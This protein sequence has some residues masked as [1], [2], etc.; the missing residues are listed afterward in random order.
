MATQ[1]NPRAILSTLDEAVLTTSLADY[2]PTFKDNVYNSNVVLRLMN[3][4]KK[5]IDGGL[6]IVEKLIEKEQDNG[7][8]YSGADV[9]ENTQDHTTT[10][11]EYRWQN[12]YEP[13]AITRDEERVN[14]GSDHKLESLIDTKI[15]LSEKAIAKRLEQALSTSVIGAGE[16]N[17]LSTV[18]N[19][20][21]LGSI[22]GSTDTFWQSTSTTSGA[23]A[24]QGLTDMSTAYYAVSSSAMEEN[25]TQLLTT[26]SIFQKYEQTRL[27]LQRIGSADLAANAGFKSLT[28]KGVPLIYG[29]Y[30]DSGV[31]YGL[32]L[33]YLYLA[34]DSATDLVTTEFR[35][36][37]NQMT[38][39]AYILWRGNL[40][41]NNRRRHFKLTS[42][43]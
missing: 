35:K 19:T 29:N 18:V 5:T 42:I 7:G 3:Q 6:S 4:N 13:I 32:N 11:V 26:K 20:G 9:L 10:M 37:V 28:F 21:T 36:P 27:P 17:D 23:F 24:T 25:P 8:F 38:K 43:T 14:S 39:V 30:I 15:M 22:N 12:V 40:V 34:V 16:L 31:M 1:V 2:Q 33:N 41:T